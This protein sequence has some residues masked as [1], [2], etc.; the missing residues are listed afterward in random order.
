MR[1]SKLALIGLIASIGIHRLDY[2]QS[3][4]TGIEVKNITIISPLFLPPIFIALTLFLYSR[5]YTVQQTKLTQ[6]FT[7]F[8]FLFVSFI[9]FI[10]IYGYLIGNLPFFIGTD[11]WIY[12]MIICALFLGKYEMVWRD[13]EQILPWFFLI[14]FIA[15]IIAIPFPRRALLES[16]SVEYWADKG[17]ELGTTASLAYDISP[18]LDFWPLIFVLAMINSRKKINLKI[19]I[20]LSSMFLYLGLQLFFTK[21]A[22]SIRAITYIFAIITLYQFVFPRSLKGFKYI[23]GSIIAF[24]LLISTI[25]IDRLVDK[26]QSKQ[27]D[28][29]RQ[30]EILIMLSQLNAYEWLI[31]KGMGGYFVLGQANDDYGLGAY[32]VNNRG[33]VGKTVMHIGIGY[34]LL[35]GGLIFFSFHALFVMPILLRLFNR[36]WLKGKYNFTAVILLSVYCLFRFIEGPFSTGHSFDGLVF[37]FCCGKLVSA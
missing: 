30:S 17:V 19:I 32:A 14:F 16:G 13:L 11:I 2:L 4:F 28:N 3:L 18:V 15:V 23:F 9:L 7:Y 36:K 6:Q 12:F 5:N 27:A 24:S 22:P 10:T 29:S 21:R 37:G 33:D 1:A 34:P 8:Y 25:S 31:G 20:S 26:F 35:K